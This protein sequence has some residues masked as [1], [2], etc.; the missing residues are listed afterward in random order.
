MSDFCHRES[1]L[2]TRVY[3]LSFSR[4][5]EAVEETVL[6]EVPVLVKPKCV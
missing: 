2:A 3:L 4:A 1:L 6:Q 5:L